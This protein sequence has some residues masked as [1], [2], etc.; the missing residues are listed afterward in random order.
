ML[1]TERLMVRPFRESDYADLY[2][3]LS[4]EETYRFEPGDPVSLEEAEK[5]NEILRGRKGKEALRKG[6]FPGC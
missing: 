4:I 6:N 2:E 1:E 3:Y 5:G